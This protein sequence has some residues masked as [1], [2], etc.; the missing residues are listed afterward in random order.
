VLGDQ[1][2]NHAV[3]TFDFNGT[4]GLVPSTS[5]SPPASLFSF[6]L[7]L[8]S[9]GV[10]NSV[11]LGP[12]QGGL[13]AYGDVVLAAVPADWSTTA[14]SD[15]GSG[16]LYVGAGERLTILNGNATL[17]GASAEGPF[18]E[19]LATQPDF[20]PPNALG[21]STSPYYSTTLGD[22][23][24]HPL[25]I[26]RCHLGTLDSQLPSTW[27]TAMPPDHVDDAAIVALRDTVYNRWQWKGVVQKCD[28]SA[29]GLLGW[30][31]DKILRPLGASF[32]TNAS[33]QVTV[34]SLFDTAD[35]TLPVVGDD[36]ILDGRGVSFDL[37]LGVDSIRASTAVLASGSYAV[38]V[39]GTGAYSSR[40]GITRQPQVVDL[41]ADGLVSIS[42]FGSA[43]DA[44]IV[45]Y[46]ERLARIAALFRMRT[47]TLELTVL[48]AAGLQAGQYRRLAVRGLRDPV[49]G[50][51]PA[52]PSERVGY[53][54]AVDNDPRR[55]VAKVTV[56]MLPMQP[57]RIGP[58]ALVTGALDD[59]TFDV[60]FSWFVDPLV[61]GEY[62]YAPSTGGHVKNDAMQFVP[63]DYV[64][65]RTAGLAVA[66]LPTEVVSVAWPTMVC[67][68]LVDIATGLPY[69]PNSK[70]VVTFADLEDWTHVVATNPAAFAYFDQTI[71]G[72]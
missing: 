39:F 8:R 38:Q 48:M 36:A 60:E 26:L 28:G 68:P 54:T 67:N 19:V 15:A 55:D 13:L 50:Q 69:V 16:L 64:V 66:T 22:V 7:A 10:A 37:E 17:P 47:Q 33:G 23:A 59:T 18:Y 34:R 63:G 9:Q 42:D 2:V 30:L 24:V 62:L 14:L 71:F 57:T 58:A 56:V 11:I 5:F 72:I 65:V 31:T 12:A 40:F 46:A 41:Q 20:Y 70:D 4:N 61:G 29:T 52:A 45:R 25:D 51:L 3:A 21:M 35:D 32:T 1:Q 27:V 49:T 6:V 44:T 43:Q 53:V